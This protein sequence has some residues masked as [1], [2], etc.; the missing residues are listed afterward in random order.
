ME[1]LKDDFGIPKR[2]FSFQTCLLLLV[3]ICTLHGTAQ[4]FHLDSRGSDGNESQYQP[5]TRQYWN[6]CSLFCS[7]S[8]DN[9][10]VIVAVAFNKLKFA[11]L[12]TTDAQLYVLSVRPSLLSLKTNT[13]DTRKLNQKLVQYLSLLDVCWQKLANCGK[14]STNID[15]SVNRR[16]SLELLPPSNPRAD[17][18]LVD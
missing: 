2:P 3:W 16:P 4:L 6:D 10:V 18:K 9:D 11:I 17:A 5:A 7:K 14:S 8:G 1:R 13:S 15:R 12:N